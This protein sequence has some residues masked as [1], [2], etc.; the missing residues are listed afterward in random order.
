MSSQLKALRKVVSSDLVD[1]IGSYARIFEGQVVGAMRNTSDA[2]KFLMLSPNRILIVRQDF[3]EIKKLDGTSLSGFKFRYLITAIAKLSGNRLAVGYKFSK[4]D[5]REDGY[6][7]DEETDDEDREIID[8][9]Q[10]L[11]LDSWKTLLTVSQPV[12]PAE[13]DSEL[14]GVNS[15]HQISEDRMVCVSCH[16]VCVWNMDTGELINRTEIEDDIYCLS[17]LSS[18][19]FAVGTSGDIYILKA[20]T[21]VPVANVGQKKKKEP[22]PTIRLLSLPETS[23]IACIT[24]ERIM[25]RDAKTLKLNNKFERHSKVIGDRYSKSDDIDL[26]LA[27]GGNLLLS[28]VKNSRNTSVISW[29]LTGKRGE[30]EIIATN[31]A[32]NLVLFSTDT[33]LLVGSIY[34]GANVTIWE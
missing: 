11:D 22:E 28:G 17:V 4:I 15:I 5:D 9:I 27:P 2:R 31:V 21:L 23:E 33:Q 19:D 30:H 7:D 26:V 29:K 12:T 1:L 24:G 6:D 3:I 18:G 8:E 20:E 25:I 16:Y 13:E 10:I 32:P 14:E 34:S